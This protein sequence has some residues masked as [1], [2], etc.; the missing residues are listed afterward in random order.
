MMPRT[1]KKQFWMS[2]EE[3]TDLANKAKRCGI[4]EAAVVRLLLS[5]FQP[6]EKPGDEFYREMRNLSA[7][8]NNL[9]Q[10]LIRAHTL[11]FIDTPMLIREIDKLNQFQLKIERKFLLPEESE[12]WQ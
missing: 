1:I 11:R 7:I 8:G 5:G 10:L 6:R 12:L 9:N 4:S 3:A 2:P